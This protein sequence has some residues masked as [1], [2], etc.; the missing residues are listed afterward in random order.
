MK[1]VIKSKQN[2]YIMIMM[3]LAI[4]A[5]SV[6]AAISLIDS[7]ISSTQNSGEM[8]NLA[9][10]KQ[11]AAA[12]L[13][14]SLQN[15]RDNNDY[16]GTLNL[17]FTEGGCTATTNRLSASSFTIQSSG[18]SLSANANLSATINQTSPKITISAWQEN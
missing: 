18:L 17:S 10:A 6:A 14:E 7:G 12:C 2:G 11:Y 16:S 3:V 8:F 13:E 15:I 5:I 4:S 9:R 1:E